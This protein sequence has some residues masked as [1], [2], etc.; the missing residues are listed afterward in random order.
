M[1]EIVTGQWQLGGHKETNPKALF[2]EGVTLERIEPLKYVSRGGQKL[3]QAL[4]DFDLLKVV[5]GA[6]V[7]DAGAST[8]GF[9]DCLLQA[10]TSLVYAC[11][12]GSNQLDWRLRQDARVRVYEKTNVMDIPSLSLEPAPDWAVADIAFRSSVS[13]VKTLLP[14]LKQ[15]WM[16]VLIK[17]Q[18][19]WLDSPPDYKGVVPREAYAPI[20]TGVGER[21]AERGIKVKA[22]APSGLKGKKQGNQEFFFW[23]SLGSQEIPYVDLMEGALK[24]AFSSDRDDL[25]VC[26]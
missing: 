24:R 2:K 19:E 7:L 15:G 13:V 23:V 10:G 12:V 14:I 16:L 21:L 8:G 18:F 1:A 17:P 26:Q 5:K 4:V 20:L 9:T 3:E 11:D 22:M 25:K 6:V